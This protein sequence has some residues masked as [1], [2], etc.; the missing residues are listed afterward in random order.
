MK[1]NDANGNGRKVE[2]YLAKMYSKTN[3]WRKCYQ[4]KWRIIS[5]TTIGTVFT[6][7]IPGTKLST[8]IGIERRIEH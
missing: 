1:Q 7:Q 6:L 8:Q 3:N 5:I 2:Q 4:A